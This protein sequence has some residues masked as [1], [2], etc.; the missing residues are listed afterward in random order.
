MAILTA[1]R[2]GWIQYHQPSDY[3]QI[4]NGMVDLTNSSFTTHEIIPMEGEWKYYP[5][6]F[7]TPKEASIDQFNPIYSYVPSDWE[8]PLNTDKKQVAYGY[9]TY[10]LQIDL[11]VRDPDIYGIRVSN[12]VSAAAVYVNGELV[13]SINQPTTSS[14]QYANERGPFIGHFYSDKQ[15][16]DVIIHISNYDIPFFKGL[17][18]PV[19]F[20]LEEAISQQYQHSKTLQ[21]SI[22]I[23]I[24]LHAVYAITLVLMGKG[25]YRIAILY[26]GIMLLLY[27]LGIL[28]DDNILVQLPVPMVISYKLLLFIFVSTLF[29]LLLFIKKVYDITHS[30]FHF[31]SI[32][33]LILVLGILII[34]FYL[35]TFLGVVVFAFY[36]IAI[37]YL[38]IQSFQYISRGKEG[39]IFVLLFVSSYISNITWGFLIKMDIV[40]FPYY[41]FDFLL[42]VIFIALLLF[43]QQ[44]NIM[45]TKEEQ[46]LELQ[47][48]DKKK[49]EFLAHASHEIRNPL[50][51]MINIAQVTLNEANHL[52]PKE[53][54]YLQLLIQTGHQ[55][56]Y[57][58]NDMLDVTRIKENRIKMNQ[59]NVNLYRVVASSIE[60]IKFKASTKNIAIYL[61][62]AEE[63]PSVYA[64]EILLTRIIFNLLDNSVKYTK[65]GHIRIH[66]KTK[67]KKVQ[68]TITDTGIGMNQVKLNKVFEAYETD[69]D[70][71]Y[72]TEGIGLGLYLCKELVELHGGDIHITSQVGVGTSISF[73]IPLASDSSTDVTET[74]ITSK[75]SPKPILNEKDKMNS[76]AEQSG[77]ILI[78]D[79]D[80]LNLRILKQLLESQYEIVTVSS[81]KKALHKLE[82]QPFDLMVS[83]VMMPSMSGYELTREIRKQFSVSQLPILLLTALHQMENVERGFKLGAN[84]YITK[85]VN[86]VELQARIDALIML[87]HA[88]AQQIQTEA[89]WYQAQ[90]KPHFLFNT[91]NAIMSLSEIDHKR[92]MDL[93]HSFTHFLRRSFDFSNS[94]TFVRLKEEISLSKAYVYI[95]ETRFQQLTIHWDITPESL[96]TEIPPLI[97]QPL[98]ENAIRHGILK[99]KEPGVISITIQDETH[100]FLVSIS[101]NGVGMTEEKVANILN[102]DAALGIGISNTNKRLQQHFNHGLTIY[103]KLNKGT[104]VHFTIPKNIG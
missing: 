101:D 18:E 57:T 81:G 55:L 31:F 75:N 12:A 43:K 39:S 94:A 62:N 45:K 24:L 84:D 47:Q 23:I 79:D 68:I 15:T 92:M 77:R 96:E 89:A 66:T 3:P 60:L 88:V 90:M 82:Q 56:T 17:T 54:E 33:Y 5:S 41:P 61:D 6:K 46:T 103:S 22:S 104:T 26:Y 7:L 16:L 98:V 97:I 80:Q 83:D 32:G 59:T 69:E 99:Q 44:I 86:Y 36:G 10:R 1:G 42:S 71:I 27:G 29:A 21:L 9:G 70:N 8:Y 14:S 4:K 13:T 58:L 11:P 100:H 52:T 65:Q 72:S 102:H 20:G 91:L 64:D 48:Q 34:P 30:F 37:V 49:D 40:A 35:Y 76:V 50:H 74:M 73:T 95:M 2:I 25:K 67:G 87:K 19:N 53:Q 78:V 85:P 38:L 93:L 28:I 63:I 51:G